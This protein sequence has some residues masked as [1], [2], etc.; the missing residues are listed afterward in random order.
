MSR[1]EWSTSL[2]LPTIPERRVWGYTEEGEEI[3][4]WVS[5]RETVLDVCAR[6]GE[7]NPTHTEWRC[8]KYDRC[9]WCENTGGYGYLSWHECRV[10]KVVYPDL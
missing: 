8:P 2:P 9:Y 6:C 4:V 7:A 1:E 3:G 5:D 10:D